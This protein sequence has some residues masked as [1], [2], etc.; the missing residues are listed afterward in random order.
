MRPC[1]VGGSS[2]ATAASFSGSSRCNAGVRRV[3]VVTAASTSGGEASGPGPGLF[4]K[5][6]PPRTLTAKTHNLMLHRDR[7]DILREKVTIYTHPGYSAECAGVREAELQAFEDAAAM[8]GGNGASGTDKG[9]CERCEGS[10]RSDCDQCSGVGRA[11]YQSQH[12]L[13]PGEYPVWCPKCQGS[14]RTYC[15][16]CHGTGTN[17]FQ[18]SIGF[19][20]PHEVKE[21]SAG[22]SP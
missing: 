4:P 18:N 22:K 7:H 20:L 21:K 6:S 13:P 14:G 1:C 11:N 12:V 10:G 16:Q 9:V 19:R 8:M 5:K 17:I 15:G 3:S 2:C